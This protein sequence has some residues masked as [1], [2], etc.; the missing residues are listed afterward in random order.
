MAVTYPE[1]GNKVMA[2]VIETESDC[3]IGMKPGDEFELST[4]KCGQFCGLFYHNIHGWV[5]TLQFEGTFPAGDDPD[6]Q[7]WDCPNPTNRVKVE[8]RRIKE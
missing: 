4:H 2:K 7:V 3:T 1:I 6:V 5:Q 8:L